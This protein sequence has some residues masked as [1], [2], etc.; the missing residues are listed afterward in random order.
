[1]ADIEDDSDAPLMST[2]RGRAIAAVFAWCRGRSIAV[3]Y[4]FANTAP[5]GPA[6]SLRI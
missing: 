4:A 1:M 5:K 2:H 3:H 6:N